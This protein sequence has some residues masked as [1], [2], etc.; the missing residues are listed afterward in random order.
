[1][2]PSALSAGIFESGMYL[3]VLCPIQKF[4]LSCIWAHLVRL[5]GVE[6]ERIWTHIVRLAEVNKELLLL[7]TPSC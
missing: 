1:M 2:G 6:R 3:L 5:E 7:T 4:P